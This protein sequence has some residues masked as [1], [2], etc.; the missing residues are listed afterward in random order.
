MPGRQCERLR[1]LAGEVEPHEHVE[2][3]AHRAAKHGRPRH[4]GVDG[5]HPGMGVRA[6]LSLGGN[7]REIAGWADDRL[8]D[9]VAAVT[10]VDRPARESA[11]R[12]L[13]SYVEARGPLDERKDVDARQALVEMDAT[14]AVLEGIHHVKAGHTLRSPEPAQLRDIAVAWHYANPAVAA[15]FVHP[16]VATGL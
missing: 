14:A 1:R 3:R 5:Q 12:L 16:M 10:E 8:G 13:W 9:C 4:L 15:H 2:H 11:P 7:N 6:P